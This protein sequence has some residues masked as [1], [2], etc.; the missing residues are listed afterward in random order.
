MTWARIPLA[1]L[2]DI[3]N[4]LGGTVNDVFLATVTGALQPL[5]ALARG[6]HR[7]PRDPVGRAGVGAR[8]G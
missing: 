4:K 6:A 8:R 1:D 5:A 2:K 7:G 3:K